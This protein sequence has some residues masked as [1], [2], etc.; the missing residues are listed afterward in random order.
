MVPVD[1]ADRASKLTHVTT[2]DTSLT[3]DATR[4]LASYSI[5]T[6]CGTRADAGRIFCRKCGSALRPPTTLIESGV[7]DVDPPANRT[8]STKRVVLAVI[9]GLAGIAAVVFWL[10]PLRTGTQVLV[11]V[12]S[13]AVFLTCHSVLTD[14]DETY[15]AKHNSAGYW[16]KPTNWTASSKAPGSNER[17]SSAET[18]P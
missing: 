12:A 13:I 2:Y 7:Q 8:G 3:D 17:P 16:P 9:R 6:Q 11:F 1:D 18:K 10:C 4:S 15:A 5:C 14:L